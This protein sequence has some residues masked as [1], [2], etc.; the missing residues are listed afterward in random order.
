MSNGKGGFIGQDGLNAPDEPTG[1]SASGGTD[2]VASVAF[3][4]PSDVGASAITGY[5]ATASTGVGATGTSSPI[6]VTGLTLG[7]AATFR[8]WAVNPF[9]YSAPSGAT[10]S[11]TPSLI[12][13]IIFGGDT[14]DSDRSG[15]T[16]VIEVVSIST[17]GNATDFG[18]LTQ[19]ASGSSAAASTTRALRGG[20]RI[21]STGN[22][23]N[24]GTTTVD[25][26]T[27]A[28]NGNATDFGDMHSERRDAAGSSN[29]TRAIF[30][31][32]YNDYS[33]SP[34]VIN[35]I[36]YFTISTT[37]NFT[38]FGDLIGSGNSFLAACSS[39]VRTIFM[40]G[41][42]YNGTKNNIIQYVT[43]ATTGNAADFGDLSTVR[44]DLAACSSATRGVS[45]G[46]IF[47]AS[48]EIMEYV[49]I[50]STGNATDFGDIAETKEHAGTSS[51]T[52]GL[53]I[54][55]ANSYGNLNK[56]DYITIA[57]VG[58]TTDFGDLTAAKRHPSATSN[59]HG[60]LQ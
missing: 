28:S 22:N 25:Y 1:V 52:R 19:T 38:D 33:G 49:T 14:A 30:G 32:G 8:V 2:G 48:P 47:D 34:Q 37:G 41:Y 13:A 23:A 55:G 39:S 5:V 40:G 59:G 21:S 29:K 45:I 3:T 7:T 27:I 60:G 18:D 50:A 57:S 36:Q 42:A 31:G 11:V 6:S 56:I 51:S 10:S 53:S 24:D 35:V 9:G 46:G 58:N 26:V 4:A 43:T 54:G 20:G 44:Y 17:T 12:R 15:I 16:N